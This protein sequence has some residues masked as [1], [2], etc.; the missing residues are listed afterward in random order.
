MSGLGTDGSLGRSVVLAGPK[1]IPLPDPQA[2]LDG[3]GEFPEGHA[4][5]LAEQAPGHSLGDFGHLGIARVC[6]ISFP[7]G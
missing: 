5:V 1:R 4:E 2:A 3:L 6:G 7:G